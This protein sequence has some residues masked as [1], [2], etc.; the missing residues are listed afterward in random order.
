MTRTYCDGISGSER[1]HLDALLRNVG[2][3]QAYTRSMHDLGEDLGR[4]LAARLDASRP[5]LLVCT[6]EDAD[7]LARGIL[8]VFDRSKLSS[9]LV[10]FWN[11]RR[12]VAGIDVA[13]IVRR[14]EE[15]LPDDVGAVVVVKSIISGAC[16]V[17]TNLL[18]VLDELPRRP[19]SI[20]VAAPVIHEGAP[21]R[22]R[23]QLP[24]VGSFDLV[25]LAA[26][27]ERDT[28]G[29]VHPGVGGS[30][31]ELYGFEDQADKNRHRPELLRSR[32][33]AAL[34]ARG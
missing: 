29:T 15:P 11:E 8:D 3:P 12:K 34:A 27:D 19:S 20:F 33:Q 17:K 4:R 6:A 24:T 13:P 14:Y 5:V 9:F 31:Y 2:D 18:E 26:D 25:W 21:N 10:C 16:V 7:S 23:E 32:R 28:D 22:L 1:G 30:V